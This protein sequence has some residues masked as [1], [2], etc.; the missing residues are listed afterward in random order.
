MQAIFV[1]I[2]CP[3]KEEAVKLCTSLLELDLCTTAK[4]HDQVQLLSKS[5]GPVAVDQIA[6]ITLKTTDLNIPAI[7]KFIFENHSW[8]DPCIEVVAILND[9]C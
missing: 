5:K 8:G 4:V 9:L 1:N 3:T 2:P 7:H 6:L